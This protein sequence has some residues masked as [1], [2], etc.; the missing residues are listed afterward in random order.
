MICHLKAGS[1]SNEEAERAAETETVADYFSG[2]GPGNYVLAGD[3]NV[4]SSAEAGYQ[5]L[6]VNPGLSGRLYDPINRPGAWNS[7]SSFAHIHT[8][9]PRTIDVGDGGVEGGL[10]DRFDQILVSGPVMTDG[11]GVKYLPGSYA[12][13]GQDG[14]HFNAALY[15]PACQHRCSGSCNRGALPGLRPPAGGG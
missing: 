9:S 7:N 12:V 15:R 2:L 11:A 1:G 4:Y 6:I 13:V 8:Q 14:M 10:D 5:N 3:L